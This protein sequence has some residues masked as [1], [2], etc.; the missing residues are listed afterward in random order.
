V[1]VLVDSTV[2]IDFLKGRETPETERL[3]GL[4]EERG[5]LC[6][7]GFVLTEVLQ[8]IRDERQYLSTREQFANLIYLHEDRSTF[9]VGATIYRNLRKQ[10][11]TIRNSIDCLIAATAI[12]NNVAL[13]ECDRDYPF[14]AAEFPLKLVMKNEA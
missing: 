12:R 10:G 9:E 4:I 7:C 13:L 1:R 3:V 8:G 5:D 11:I 14:I 6:V 2:W